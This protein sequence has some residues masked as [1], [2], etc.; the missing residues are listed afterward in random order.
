MQHDP[1]PFRKVHL[2]DFP[3][4]V[5]LINQLLAA[6]K[7]GLSI[8]DTVTDEAGLELA[9]GIILSSLGNA[10]PVVAMSL[11]GQ[12]RRIP[13]RARTKAQGSDTATLLRSIGMTEEAISRQRKRFGF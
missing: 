4:V 6:I 2:V 9:I 11:R 5:E 8:P 3:K 12:R 1:N 10:P 7:P 13:T